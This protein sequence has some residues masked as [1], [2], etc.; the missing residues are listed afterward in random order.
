MVNHGFRFQ[1]YLLTDD[2]KGEYLMPLHYHRHPVSRT[3]T[4]LLRLIKTGTG[5]V[6]HETDQVLELFST[7]HSA[8]WDPFREP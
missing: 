6:R 2:E 7:M 1:T 5:F 3:R 8:S 4:V